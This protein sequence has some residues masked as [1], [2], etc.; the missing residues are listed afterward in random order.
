MV[1]RVKLEIVPFGDEDKVREIGRLDIFNKGASHNVPAARDA[2][3]YCTYGVISLNPGDEGLFD[4]TLVHYRK[5][6][7]W[8]LVQNVL[9]TFNIRGPK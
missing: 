9:S 7:A 6:G 4:A 8:L 3:G 2:A 1:L 5:D